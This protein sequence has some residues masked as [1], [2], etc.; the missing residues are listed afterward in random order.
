MTRHVLCSDDPSSWSSFPITQA[1]SNIY[2]VSGTKEACKSIIKAEDAAH[3]LALPTSWLPLCL[4]AFG[5]EEGQHG[6]RDGSSLIRIVSNS[7]ALRQQ[8]QV[9]RPHG[10]L[11]G[12]P[13]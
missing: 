4:L 10:A 9:R 2:V 3:S 11:P 1:F 13:S 12:S 8:Q 5:L 7:P 6:A